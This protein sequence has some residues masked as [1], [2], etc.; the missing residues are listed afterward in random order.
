MAT[1]MGAILYGN[2]VT[3]RLLS[4]VHAICSTITSV[5]GTAHHQQRQEA[6]RLD[7]TLLEGVQFI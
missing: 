4:S 6:Q 1:A 7:E 3:A 5:L 2:E